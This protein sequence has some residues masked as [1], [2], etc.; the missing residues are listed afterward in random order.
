MRRP[1]TGFSPR[2]SGNRR[3]A[4]GL[5]LAGELWLR[6]ERPESRGQAL[7]RAARGADRAAYDLTALVREGN[8]AVMDWIDDL[9]VEILG[10]LVETGRSALLEALL[11]D[12]LEPA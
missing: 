1:A 5:A 8:L 12:Y 11:E 4:A 2:R 10:E 7:L 9:G 6:L 3:L